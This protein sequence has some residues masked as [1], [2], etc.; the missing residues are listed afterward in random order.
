MQRKTVSSLGGDYYTFLVSVPYKKS[1]DSGPG[2][3]NGLG[4][5]V[6]IF[7]YRALNVQTTNVHRRNPPRLLLLLL[8]KFFPFFLSPVDVNSNGH[9]FKFVVTRQLS[10]P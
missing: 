1:P 6:A 5:P 4:D 8:L 2:Q 10:A 3:D 9:K 7:N